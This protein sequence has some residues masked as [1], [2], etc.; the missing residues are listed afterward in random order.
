[1]AGQPKARARRLAAQ[2]ATTAAAE[3]LVR[4]GDDLAEVLTP[5]AIRAMTPAQQAE[6]VSLLEQRER[7]LSQRTFYALFPES[8]T[9]WPGP[10]TVVLRRHAM[11]HARG[12]YKRHLEWFAAGRQYR[13]RCLMAA[14]RVGKSVAGAYELACH[15][16]GDYPDWW[17][18]KRFSRPIQAWACGKTTETARGI[19]QRH[20]LGDVVGIEGAAGAA[21]DAARKGLDGRGVIPGPS[22]GALTWRAGVPDAVDTVQVRHKAGGWSR[23]G[24]KSYEQGR[25]AYEGTAIE[26]VWL[27][28]EPPLD[29]YGECLVRTTTTDGTVFLTF[30]PL[31]G[32]SDVVRQFQA[33]GAGLA[34]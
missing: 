34:G 4:V 7:V 22:I 24:I 26:A 19:V 13:E 23:L 20:L 8:D 18:G 12:G 31:E 6:L 9:T 11:I 2:A 5:D 15:L 1:M 30:T 16:T 10:D 3:R 14:N 17:Q 21:S 28:E 27:D 32:V 25:S 29:V 33:A